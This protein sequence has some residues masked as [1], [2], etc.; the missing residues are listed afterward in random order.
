MISPIGAGCYVLSPFRLYLGARCMNKKP[1]VL[2]CTLFFLFFASIGIPL[3]GFSFQ[4]PNDWCAGHEVPESKCTICNPELIPQFKEA[5]DWCAGHGL[6]ESVCPPCNPKEADEHEGHDHTEEPAHDPNDWCAGHDVPESKCTICNPELIPQFKE[7]G[8]WCAGHGLPESVCPP[9]NPKEEADQ[10]ERV[11]HDWCAGHQVPESKCTLCNPELIPQFKESG[12]WCAEHEL[13][14]SVCPTCNAGSFSPEMIEARVVKFLNSELEQRAGIKTVKAERGKATEAI[15][16]SAWF[17]F[18]ADRVADLRAVI[19]GVVRKIHAELGAQVK[20]GDPI[21]TL[22]SVRIADTQAHLRK[23]RERKRLATTN[24]KRLQRLNDQGM[25][26]T[27][28]LELAEQELELASA[29]AEAAQ[30]ELELAGASLGDKPGQLTIVAPISGTL[31]R[32][33]AMLGTQATDE[34][35]LGMIADTS[36]LWVLCEVPEQEIYNVDIGARVRLDVGDGKTHEGRI[37]W[38]SSEVDSRSRTIH[39]HAVVDNRDGSLRA[40]QFAQ[41]EIETSHSHNALIIP[42]SALQRVENFDVVFVRVQSGLYEPRV[43]TSRRQGKMIAVEGRL[44]P[45][46]DIVTTGAVLLRTEVMPGSIGAGCCEV[47]ELGEK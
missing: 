33:P 5:G 44:K 18:H 32:R 28:D 43:V 7:A 34:I 8:D 6:P 14:E 45:G 41:A 1:L 36:E 13:P 26:T 27:R 47:E 17:S 10:P 9:C 37:T 25:T 24:L 31:V 11:V 29:E 38:I 3:Q 22:S 35:S 21:F 42:A 4:D 16:A 39:V 23:A 46:D 20:E 15:K 30:A 12:D 40:K 2:I 19:P